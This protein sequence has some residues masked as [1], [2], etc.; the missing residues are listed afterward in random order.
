MVSNASAFALLESLCLNASG[1]RNPSWAASFGDLPSMLEDVP[2]GWTRQA[3][4][5]GRREEARFWCN[6]EAVLTPLGESAADSP[7]EP[8]AVTLRD[9]SRHG[10][11]ISH[12]A[13]LPYRMVQIRFACE[14]VGVPT[15]IV[16][17]QWC[18][19]LAPGEYES[20]GRIQR[21]LLPDDD[22]GDQTVEA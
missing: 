8:I 18:R 15:L 17:L 6:T 12:A 20:G 3:P 19:F 7:S 13:P 2:N 10:V 9:I 16:R 4:A 14:G 22:H 21:V 11:G 1:R 5:T